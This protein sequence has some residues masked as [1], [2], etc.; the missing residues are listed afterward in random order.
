MVKSS[1]G[2]PWLIDC[3]R[4][5]RCFSAAPSG[6]SSNPSGLG[7]ASPGKFI[8]NSLLS[9]VFKEQSEVQQWPGIA[10]SLQAWNGFDCEQMHNGSKY[11]LLEKPDSWVFRRCGCSGFSH[12]PSEQ[13]SRVNAKPV[14]FKREGM[15]PCISPSTFAKREDLA[16]SGRGR[17]DGWQDF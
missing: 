11:Y 4:C 10:V 3:S 12:I 16:F 6:T 15:S 9:E 2:L 1:L 8:P 13:L 7:E 17:F 5:S 14:T